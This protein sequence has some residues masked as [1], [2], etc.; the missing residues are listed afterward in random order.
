MSGNLGLVKAAGGTLTLSNPTGNSYIGG[1]TINGGALYVINTGN[2]PNS[3]TGTGN[4]VVNASGTLGGNGY[5]GGTVKVATSGTV[6]PGYT[7][8]PATID[9]L[10]VNALQLNSGANLNMDIRGQTAQVGTAPI[11]GGIGGGATYGAYHDYVDVATGNLNLNNSALNL[12]FNTGN[13]FTQGNQTTRSG[14]YITLVQVDSGTL[15][16]TFGTLAVNGVNIPGYG[17]GG[18]I[19]NDATFWISQNG[20]TVYPSDPWAVSLGGD[21][22]NPNAVEWW[23]LYNVN[24]GPNGGG[25]NDYTFGG[26]DV[27]L[28]NVPEPATIVMLVGAAVMGLGGLVWRRKRFARV[29]DIPD[30]AYA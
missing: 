25:G 10:T 27:V 22:S 9:A 15:S 3:S 5:I 4:V 17:P 13:T 24:S 28:T 2:G 19:A 8:G 16:G 6:Y 11:V 26:N 12:N 18:T 29:D 20:Q 23:V 1:S 21:G 30:E 14:E 7:R